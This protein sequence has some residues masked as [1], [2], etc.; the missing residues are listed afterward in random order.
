[1]WSEVI[2]HLAKTM[3]EIRERLPSPTCGTG[4]RPIKYAQFEVRNAKEIL[5]FEGYRSWQEAI[6]E[7][8]KDI[9][10]MESRIRGRPSP[11]LDN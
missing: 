8:V 10:R 9:L 7:A 11:S 2:V 6:E 3:P 1:M 5:G 4:P